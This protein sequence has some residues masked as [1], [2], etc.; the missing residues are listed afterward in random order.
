MSPISEPLLIND[1]CLLV[2]DYNQQNIYQ[3][4]PDSGEVRALPMRPCQPVSMTFDPSIYGLYVTCDD[5]HRYR[6]HKKTFD[7]KID[8][9][10]Y[11]A[12]QSTFARNIFVSV[13]STLLPVEQNDGSQLR[14]LR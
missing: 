6:I 11:N 2:A 1:E 3:L 9:I 8:K 5:E 14:E 13:M 10:I 12:P 4:M 7:G